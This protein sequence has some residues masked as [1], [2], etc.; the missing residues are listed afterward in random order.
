MRI[1]F[2]TSPLNDA[3]RA[4]ITHPTGARITLT[5]H[6]IGGWIML[7]SHISDRARVLRSST[8]PTG[9]RITIAPWTTLAPHPTDARISL[10]FAPHATCVRV[11]IP[12]AHVQPAC[13]RGSRS[14]NVQPTDGS[15]SHP[16]R[17]RQRS[18]LRAREDHARSS[19]QREDHATH[20][21]PQFGM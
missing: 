4:W 7:A 9:V 5:S 19:D 18:S 21:S 3:Q 13:A 10:L 15:L 11:R 8:Q 17:P 16:H 1:T 14:P 2:F 12:I 6:P 20:F